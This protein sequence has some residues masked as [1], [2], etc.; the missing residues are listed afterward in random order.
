MPIYEFY[1]PDCHTLFS[2][3]SPRIDTAAAPDCPRCGRADLGRKPSRFATLKH[4]GDQAPDPLA[5]LDDARLEGAM[6]TLMHE[7]DGAEESDDPR[8]M[9]A[10]VRR[11]SE[12]TG[13]TLGE[14]MEDMVRRLEA[15]EDPDQLEQEMG[16]GGAEGDGEG[17]DDGALDELFQLRKALQGRRARPRVDDQLY[18]L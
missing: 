10:L 2:F 18:F 15:G 3:F 9:G 8:A 6:N 4:R 7:L 13:L 5:D 1:C 16:D 12:L 17:A 14:R 11:F